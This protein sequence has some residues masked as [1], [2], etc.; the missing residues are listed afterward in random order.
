[1]IVFVVLK[2][3]N[4]V[5]CYINSQKANVTEKTVVVVVH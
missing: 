5:V 1:M 4:R 3:I 2:S